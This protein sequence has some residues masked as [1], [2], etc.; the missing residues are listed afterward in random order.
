MEWAK[1]DVY[2]CLDLKELENLFQA[3]DDKN[4]VSSKGCCVGVTV[5][6]VQRV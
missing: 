2:E 3:R 4:L 1:K 6:H 5:R